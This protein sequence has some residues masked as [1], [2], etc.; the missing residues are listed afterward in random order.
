M[1]DDG[2]S[3]LLEGAWHRRAFAVFRVPAFRVYY[4]GLLCSMCGFWMRLAAT[5]WLVYDIT[6]SKEKLGLITAASL[7][8]WVVIAP[9]AGVIADRANLRTLLC[10]V[11]L[12]IAA[13]N[14]LLGFGLVAGWVGV[15]ELVVFSIVLGCLRGVEN[16]MRHSLV[17]R[18]V[19]LDL[20]PSA[21]GMNAAG[22]HLMNAF[23]FALGGILYSFGAPTTFFAISI[24]TIPMAF[25]ILRLSRE[26]GEPFGDRRHVVRELA[27]GFRYVRTHHLTRNIMTG[28]FLL[29]FFL[30]TYRTVMP[31]VAKD[32]LGLDSRGYGWLMAMSGVGSLISAL[33]IASRADTLS[34]RV[35]RMIA[36]ALLTCGALLALALTRDLVIATASILALGFCQVGF[37]ATANTTVQQTVPDELRGRVM[38]IWALM[39]GAAFPLGGYA[40]AWVAEI[41][42]TQRALVVE[43][44]FGVVFTLAF[45]VVLRTW[46]RGRP[47]SPDASP[48]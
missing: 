23:G 19:S 37:M 41:W 20:L 36:L 39:F 29:I 9:L 4:A 3:P 47:A 2:A 31:A 10:S 38:G 22:F 42:S 32:S 33:W 43:A 15:T 5:G 16:P 6:G 27:E 35:R 46:A 40:V 26:I 13:T 44:G 11:Y 8:P 17:R 21:I 12:L 30:L 1:S 14:A 28:A 25:Q 18:I 7:M 45:V 48:P 24:V 34:G